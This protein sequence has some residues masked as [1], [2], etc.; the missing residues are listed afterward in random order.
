MPLT[1]SQNPRL[2]ISKSIFHEAMENE[3]KICLLATESV[4]QNYA[5]ACQLEV[6]DEGLCSFISCQDEKE[7]IE[8]SLDISQ[9]CSFKM[10]HLDA[11]NVKEDKRLAKIKKWS[12][13][14]WSQTPINGIFLTV[15]SGTLE[16]KAFVGIALNKQKISD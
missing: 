2:V 4:L 14:L 10:C 6:N 1:S 11:S 16:Q 13:R 7:V 5:S 9:D 12:K 8:K 3:K 15:W